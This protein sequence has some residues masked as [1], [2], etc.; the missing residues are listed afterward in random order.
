MERSHV[1]GVRIEGGVQLYNTQ[2]VTLKNVGVHGSLDVGTNDHD[3][4]NTDNL[5][6]D[7]WIW[8]AGVRVVGATR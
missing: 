2:R 7:A 8:S 6:E 3:Q 1:E 5:V 4:G